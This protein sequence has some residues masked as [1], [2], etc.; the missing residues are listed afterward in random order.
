MGRRAPDLPVATDDK[1]R[2]CRG[3]VCCTYI[4]QKIPAPRTRGDFDHLLWQVAHRGVEL[5]KDS[6]GWHLLLRAPCDQLLPDGRCG[7]YDSRLQ[8]CRD[9]DNA[10]CER[11]EPAARHFSLH[12]TDH[13]SL[14]AYCRSRFERW[15]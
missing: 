11:D 7:I 15:R 5:F 6:G 3:S 4:T 13:A 1:C 8:V 9:Y 12:F 10:W 14:L 2:G